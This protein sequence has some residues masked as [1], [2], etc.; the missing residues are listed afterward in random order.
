MGVGPPLEEVMDDCIFMILVIWQFQENLSGRT[1]S[2]LLL[3]CL[4]TIRVV[5]LG[6]MW[7]LVDLCK[8]RGRLMEMSFDAVCYLPI[9]HFRYNLIIRNENDTLQFFGLK[10]EDLVTDP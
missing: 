4:E 8:Q 9:T 5:S 7:I 2:A 3:G 1:R 6:Q 10:R